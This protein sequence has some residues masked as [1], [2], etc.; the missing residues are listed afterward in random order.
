MDSLP[1]HL[2][3]M[4]QSAT[5][6]SGLHGLAEMDTPGVPAVTHICDQAVYTYQCSVATL[7]YFRQAVIQWTLTHVTLAQGY[8]TLPVEY[9][10]VRRSTQLSPIS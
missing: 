2:K 3:S 10:L 6:R 5:I 9:S 7:E 8:W 1:V 4:F